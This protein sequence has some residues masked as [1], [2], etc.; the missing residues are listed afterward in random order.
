LNKNLSSVLR[1]AFF[2]GLGVLLFW[3]VLRNQNLELIGQNLAK[4]DYKWALLSLVFGFVSNI[5]RSARWNMLLKPLGYKPRFINTFSAVIIAY[6]A[7]L[8]LPRLGEVTRC[9]ILS[10][11]EG[12]PMDKSFGTVFT[13]RVIDVLCLFICI[14]ITL[15]VEFDKVGGI[16]MD[17]IVTPMTDKFSN[18]TY[19]FYILLIGIVVML[20]GVVY[21]GWKYFSHTAVFAK[22]KN[23]MRG[24]AQGIQS[25][26]RVDNIGWFIFHT[27]CMWLM[28]WM[29]AYMCFFAFDFTSGLSPF[30]AFVV[31]VFGAFGFAA[32]VQG[33]FGVYHFIVSQTLTQYGVAQENGMSYAILA[34][35]AQTVAVIVFGLVALVALPF[36]N[37]NKEFASG[38]QAATAE[39]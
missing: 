27:V 3:L 13:E 12:V 20:F 10:R 29:M 37:R 21:V 16:A 1:V 8:G 22:I 2:L 17:F 5:N 25:V 38:K 14:C 39:K 24:F 19:T 26:R 18:A 23:V 11:Y 6:F 9:A 4:A 15:F 28:Y 36:I 35:A 32:P 34:H 31:T 30:T 7:N 33:G